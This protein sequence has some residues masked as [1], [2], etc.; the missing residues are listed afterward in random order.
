MALKDHKGKTKMYTAM[1]SEWRQFGHPRKRRS[2]ESVV[3]DSN[4][5]E[6]LLND[7]REFIEH[8]E[9]YSERG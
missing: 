5:G 7:C 3:L 4:I 1:G 6:R 2:L 8:P 9:W